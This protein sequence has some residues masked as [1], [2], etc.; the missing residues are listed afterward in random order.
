S[1][2]ICAL[3]SVVGESEILAVWPIPQ[4]ALFRMQYIVAVNVMLSNNLSFS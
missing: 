1:V 4:P 3:L 2:F